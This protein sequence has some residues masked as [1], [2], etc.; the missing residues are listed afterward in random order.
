MLHRPADSLEALG[1]VGRNNTSAATPAAL[2]FEHC[3]GSQ[4]QGSQVACD[5]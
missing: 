3:L 2:G 1:P 5:E 4:L